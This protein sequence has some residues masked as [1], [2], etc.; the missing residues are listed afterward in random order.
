M[1]SRRLFAVRCSKGYF[2]LL[3][4]ILYFFFTTDSLKTWVFKSHESEKKKEKESKTALQAQQLIPHWYY[5][6]FFLIS[7]SGFACLFVF[8]NT[9]EMKGISKFHLRRDAFYVQHIISTLVFIF[10]RHPRLH[11]R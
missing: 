1:R 5:L 10:G 6:E 2:C 8:T 9:G 3:L 7:K 4:M 11:R